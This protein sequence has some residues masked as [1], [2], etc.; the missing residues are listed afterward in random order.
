MGAESLDATDIAV[1]DYHDG[2]D[3]CIWHAGATEATLFTDSA[4][5]DKPC[6]YRGYAG[7]VCANP[8]TVTLRQPLEL[9][10]CGQNLRFFLSFP[11]KVLLWRLVGTKSPIVTDASAPVCLLNVTMALFPTRMTG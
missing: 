11:S 2:K 1:S 5:A 9:G 8:K 3:G 10:Q 6:N 4:R 7:C